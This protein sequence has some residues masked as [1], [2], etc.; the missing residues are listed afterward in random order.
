MDVTAAPMPT[1]Q[2]VA[3]HA[4]ADADR[5]ARGAAAPGHLNPEHALGRSEGVAEPAL[6]RTADTAFLS[7]DGVTGA[8]EYA[9]RWLLERADPGRGSR[10]AV[11]ASGSLSKVPK[12][13][14]GSL[15]P[16]RRNA[17]HAMA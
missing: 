17:N 5:T 8:V 7:E 14:T 16:P 11:G 1:A 3:G 4:R 9:N 15:I 2:G 12:P 6:A 10:H 13:G